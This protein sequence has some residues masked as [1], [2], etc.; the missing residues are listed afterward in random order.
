MWIFTLIGILFVALL[1]VTFIPILAPIFVWILGILIFVVMLVL[2]YIFFVT[3]VPAIAIGFL[4]WIIYSA[5]KT[6]RKK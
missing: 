5:F 6:W 2:A 3:I 1:L 4:I